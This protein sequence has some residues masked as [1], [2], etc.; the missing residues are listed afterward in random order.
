[1]NA[2]LKLSAII[3]FLA[4]ATVCSGCRSPYHSDQLALAGGL[5]GAGIGAMVGE[6]TGNPESG[7]LIGAVVGAVTGSVIGES[8]DEM[9]ARNRAIIES[10]V[11][12]QV[13]GA[14]TINDVMVMTQA[15]LSE[16]VIIRH[17]QYSRMAAPPSSADLV[18]LGQAGVSDRVIQAV[19]TPPLPPGPSAMPPPVII[20]EHHFGP[21]P[22]PWYHHGHHHHS[23]HH[24]GR[25]SPEIGWGFSFHH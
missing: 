9:E 11:G 2:L 3:L 15:G 7:A 4:S 14:T 23:H 12:R 10:Q 8:M 18:T 1:M 6:S 13:R 22:T 20:E 24:H 25:H 21:P 5:T 16:E 19:Q 17:I